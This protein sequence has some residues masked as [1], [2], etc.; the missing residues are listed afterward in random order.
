MTLELRKIQ[1]IE[2]ILSIRDEA[3]LSKYEEI[4][5]R[6]RIDAYESSLK[7]LTVEEYQ[8]QILDAEEDVKAGRMVSLE[9]LQKE[10][11][12]W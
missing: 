9:D 12:K 11:E 8:Q 4:A 1:L 6:A 7:P 5:R 3:L 10:M 2:M